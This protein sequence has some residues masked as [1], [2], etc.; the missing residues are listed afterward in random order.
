MS[1]PSSL[2]TTQT[3][4]TFLWKVLQFRY[5]ES[6]TFTT[7]C[8]RFV[9]RKK[10]LQLLALVKFTRF[11]AKICRLFVTLLSKICQTKDLQDLCRGWDKFFYHQLNRRLNEIHIFNF[12]HYNKYYWHSERKK[13]KIS[14]VWMSTVYWVL[15]GLK[16]RLLDHLATFQDEKPDRD[17]Y[18]VKRE[19]AQNELPTVPWVCTF[20]NVRKQI[21]LTS[22]A[23]SC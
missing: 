1:W 16:T 11:E 22:K 6:T 14:R 10:T 17:L 18:K 2:L 19:D 12:L 4:R 3:K 7:S 5:L 21:N 13:V 8:S 23:S 9:W 15:K 20:S